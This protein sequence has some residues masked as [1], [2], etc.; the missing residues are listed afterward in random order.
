MNLHENVRKRAQSVP[1]AQLTW[2]LPPHLPLPDFVRGLTS[3]L[4]HDHCRLADQ[5]TWDLLP[6]ASMAFQPQA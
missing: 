2:S 3:K 5:L 1:A 6:V 4:R